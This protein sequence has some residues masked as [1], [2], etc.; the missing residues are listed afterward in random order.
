MESIP[1]PVEPTLVSV[2]MASSCVCSVRS[3]SLSFV[4]LVIVLVGAG[5]VLCGVC[6]MRSGWSGFVAG[7]VAG[8]VRFDEKTKIHVER[9]IA[10]GL[11]C[12]KIKRCH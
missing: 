9:R 10:E 6:C 2:V 5:E 11:S 7:G 3:D 8:V 4:E 12:R 1:Q